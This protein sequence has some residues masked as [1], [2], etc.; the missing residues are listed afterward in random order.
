MY[1][2][3]FFGFLLDKHLSTWICI[4]SQ[5]CLLKTYHS[6]P[7]LETILLQQE[8]HIRGILKQDAKHDKKEKKPSMWNVPSLNLI[9]FI[10]LDKE[11]FNFL[12]EEKD[13]YFL[14]S[15][16]CILFFLQEKGLHLQHPYCLVIRQLLTKHPTKLAMQFRLSWL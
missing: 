12:L 3:C 2:F 15:G 16:V 9:C 8:Y 13:C 7:E 10:S 1:W 11:N 6:F 14:L 5:V 4:S